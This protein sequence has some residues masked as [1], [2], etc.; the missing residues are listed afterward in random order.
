MCM[1]ECKRTFTTSN[2]TIGTMLLF[3]FKEILQA[4]TK[5][6]LIRKRV[7]HYT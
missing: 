7:N 5:I 1:M 4:N 6:I 3:I 2:V